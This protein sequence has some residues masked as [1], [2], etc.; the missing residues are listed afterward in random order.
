M[1]SN[2]LLKVLLALLTISLIVFGIAMFLRK[3]RKKETE[4]KPVQYAV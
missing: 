2:I 4:P 1:K 3:K